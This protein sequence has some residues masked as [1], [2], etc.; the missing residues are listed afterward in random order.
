MCKWKQPYSTPG[1]GSQAEI[2]PNFFSYWN[3]LPISRTKIQGQG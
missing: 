3:C 1:S 2:L